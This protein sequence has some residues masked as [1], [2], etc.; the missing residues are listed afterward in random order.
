MSDSGIRPCDFCGAKE[1]ANTRLTSEP[2][3]R[4]EDGP[5]RASIAGAILCYD[6]AEDMSD[7]VEARKRESADPVD[8]LSPFGEADARALLDRLQQNEHLVMKTARSSGYG[9]RAV[10]GELKYAVFRAPGPLTIETLSQEDVREI[11][12]NAK[13]LTLKHFD[14]S[15]WDR[16]KRAP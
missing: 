10:D 4:Y 2:T 1:A 6:C 15:A 13:R 7:Y 3:V 9:V 11:V 14:Q 16:F 5:S 12:L 8:G